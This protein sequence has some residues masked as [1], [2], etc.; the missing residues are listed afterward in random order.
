MYIGSFACLFL[1]FFM[2]FVCG[3]ESGAAGAG[4]VV[5]VAMGVCWVCHG[6]SGW[7]VCWRPANFGQLHLAVR[8]HDGHCFVVEIRSAAW[9]VVSAT[10]NGDVWLISVML[11]AGSQRYCRDFRRKADIRFE[12]SGRAP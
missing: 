4:V 8:W 2:V 7:S 6:V 12:F 1:F 9:Y 10:P 5:G 3:G 11:D